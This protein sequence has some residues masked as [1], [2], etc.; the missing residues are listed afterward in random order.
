MK[1]C[2]RHAIVAL[3]LLVV[4]VCIALFVR[5]RIVRPFVGDLLAVMLVHFALR[6]TLPLGPRLAAGIALMVA[7]MVELG[8]LIGILHWIGLADNPIAR[9]VFGTGFD[10]LDFAAYAAGAL[11][12]IAVDRSG[13]RTP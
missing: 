1:L 12:A 3:A 6:A 9:I 4:E 10:P 11:V 13:P 8:Q 5:D 7:V 2:R